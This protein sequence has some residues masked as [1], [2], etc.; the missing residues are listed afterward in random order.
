MRAFMLREEY[1]EAYKVLL[2][3]TDEMLEKEQATS[4]RARCAN[5]LRQGVQ[6]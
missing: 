2:D 1:A 5:E 3:T 6:K 4:Y